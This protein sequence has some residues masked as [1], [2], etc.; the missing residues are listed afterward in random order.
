MK[1]LVRLCDDWYAMP[2]RA[3][4]D[5]DPLGFCASDLASMHKPSADIAA[6]AVD[7]GIAFDASSVTVEEIRKKAGY[8]GVHVVIEGDLAEARCKTQI[9]VRFGDA[10]TPAPVDSVYPILL[11]TSR[12]TTAGLPDVRGH[13]R[14]TPRRRLAGHDQQPP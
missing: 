10:V 8:G 4:R 1:C 7:D 13:R 3:T 9:D 14:E 5:A 6:V 11:R 12:T 2:Q